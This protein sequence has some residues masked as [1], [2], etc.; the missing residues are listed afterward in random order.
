MTTHVFKSELWLPVPREKVFPF[1]ADARNL[2]VITPPWLNFNVLTPGEIEM[3]AG[4]F[5]DY[6][7]KIHGLPVRWRTEI[8]G[9]NP[10][11]SFCDEQRRGPY[12]RWSH[13]HTFAEKAG[14]TLCHDKV[15][16]AV[17]G[18]ALVNYLFVRRDVEKIF[19]YRAAALRKHFGVEP[20]KNGRLNQ[21]AGN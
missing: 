15:I 18:G 8:T 16:Y 10:P 9:W 11:A 7:L 20:I 2:E 14:G 13:T 3:R 5:I 12:R 1:F 21:P 17:P 19:N 6:R 4:A